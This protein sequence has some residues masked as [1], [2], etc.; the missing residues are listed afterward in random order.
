MVDRSLE[1]GCLGSQPKVGGRN[2]SKS[3]LDV[4][5][6][7]SGELMSNSAHHSPVLIACNRAEVERICWDP[8]DGELCLSRMKPEETLVEVRSGSDVQI[9]R[10]TWALGVGPAGASTG[11]DLGGS[12]KYSSEILED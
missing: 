9:D 7:G 1:S 8:K 4:A 6:M 10:L 12:S 3:H 11:A 2:E 5:D